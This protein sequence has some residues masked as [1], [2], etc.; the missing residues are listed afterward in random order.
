MFRGCRGGNSSGAHY[1]ECLA[2]V[3]ISCNRAHGFA[4]F[5]LKAQADPKEFEQIAAEYVA[6]RRKV[7]EHTKT[8]RK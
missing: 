7:F 8:T 6:Q 3:G 2:I 4:S 5:P 1:P